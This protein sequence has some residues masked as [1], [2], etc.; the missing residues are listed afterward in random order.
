M[1][2]YC[3]FIKSDT[4]SF[5]YGGI[6]CYDISNQLQTLGKK[7]T[8]LM[9][10]ESVQNRHSWGGGELKLREDDR[11]VFFFSVVLF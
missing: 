8:Y 9:A 11:R 6:N 2:C 3:Y 5:C 10:V 7:K 1:N 4:V